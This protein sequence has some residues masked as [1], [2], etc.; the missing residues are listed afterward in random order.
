ML[1]GP[2]RYAAELRWFRRFH[3]VRANQLLHAL[4]V[5]LEL[6]ASTLLLASLSPYLHW[7][8]NLSIAL[9][10]LTT[11]SPL[12][13]YCATFHIMLSCIA[14][15]ICAQINQNMIVLIFISC[16]LSA[17]FVQVIIGHHM[18]EGNNPSMA[19]KL[20]L[21]SVLWSLCMAWETFIC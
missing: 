18:I 14:E 21:S 7:I 16:Q 1:R 13:S 4:A 5:P 19:T 2:S 3:R 11:K 10:T 12:A 20:T 6:F 15:G 17:W 9:F 8:F